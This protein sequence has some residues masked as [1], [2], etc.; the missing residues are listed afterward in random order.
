MDYA[1]QYLNFCSCKAPF[2]GYHI[3]NTTIFTHPSFWHWIYSSSSDW[4]LSSCHLWP[5]RWWS[6]QFAPK[7]P[8]RGNKS[9]CPIYT[10]ALYPGDHT[11]Q[12]F[13][14]FPLVFFI[15]VCPVIPP[16]ILNLTTGRREI[17][18]NLKKSTCVQHTWELLPYRVCSEWRYQSL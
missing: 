7:V 3:C 11:L 1:L 4:H 8:W 12:H 2:L 17:L 15:S 6:Y 16:L 5:T 18:I 14:W 10:P 13:G 9:P